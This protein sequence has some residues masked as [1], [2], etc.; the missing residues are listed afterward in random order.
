MR[1]ISTSWLLTRLIAHRGYH[2]A[3]A[4]E[5]SLAAFSRA[6]EADF[7]IELDVHLLADGTVVVFHDKTLSRVTDKDGYIS[8]LTKD[9]LK[10]IYLCGTKEKIPTFADVLGLVAGKV[11]ILVEIKSDGKIGDL[12]KAIW[13]LLKDYKGEYAVQSFNPYSV[14]WFVHNAPQVLRGQL[15]CYFKGEKM[16]RIRKTVLKKLRF[17][18]ISKPDFIAY[19]H[20]DLPNRYVKK[21][22]LPV[23]AWTIRNQDEYLRV[24]NHC[25][26]VIF[27][28]PVPIR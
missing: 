11:P 12:E 13:E 2:N 10:D 6:I 3:A 5:N 27:E 28:G 7:P 17:N 21:T 15:S 22:K 20:E 9:D 24:S 8:K 25:D 4:P 19:G 26:N 1:D 23:L 18:K 16:S 14:G